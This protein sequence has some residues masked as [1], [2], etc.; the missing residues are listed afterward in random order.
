MSDL[1]TWF[2]RIGRTVVEPKIVPK[3]FG[4]GKKATSTKTRTKDVA[5]SAPGSPQRAP[6]RLPGE[7]SKVCAIFWGHLPEI[8][9]RLVGATS[10]GEAPGERHVS[11]II[12]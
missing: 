1:K 4:E 11:K 6:Q 5:K 9:P 10:A 7:P 12:D 8:D 2:L 3:S